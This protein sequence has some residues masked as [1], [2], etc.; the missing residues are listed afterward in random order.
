[1]TKGE[2]TGDVKVFVD[3]MLG[4]RGQELVKKH[5]YL[6]LKDLKN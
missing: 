6:P 4:D 5:G 1:L 2:P 3:F